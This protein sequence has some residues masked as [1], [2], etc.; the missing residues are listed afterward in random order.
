MDINIKDLPAVIHSCFILHNFYEI[1]QEAV[2]QNDVPVARSYDI[3]FQPETET[4]YEISNNEAGGIRSET[5]FLN[6][7]NK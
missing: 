3:E 2:S 4:K 1:R 5:S 7:L 6:I